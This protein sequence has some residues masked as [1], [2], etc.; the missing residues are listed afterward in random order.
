MT[1]KIGNTVEELENS[2]TTNGE[3]GYAADTGNLVIKTDT[4]CNKLSTSDYK[5]SASDCNLNYYCSDIKY[6][7]Y[8]NYLNTVNEKE[9]NEI[10][11]KEGFIITSQKTLSP[12]ETS[13][14]IG[15][16]LL[17]EKSFY[18]SYKN[19]NDRETIIQYQTP[20][21]DG[22]NIEITIIEREKT[23]QLFITP[24][25]IGTSWEL[26]EFRE[27]FIDLFNKYIE[28]VKTSGEFLEDI[29]SPRLGNLGIDGHD[30]WDGKILGPHSFPSQGD[31]TIL[32]L[33]SSSSALDEL[34]GKLTYAGQEEI[35]K[36]I[37][38][39]SIDTNN[40]ITKT[41]ASNMV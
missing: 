23:I 4:G 22:K 31:T 36:T 7:K 30:L 14:C 24:E 1:F 21:E 25:S 35:Q 11:E 38:S 29:P 34:T 37:T 18:C 27:I 32:G 13:S 5:L 2:L 16:T 19:F 9:L 12:D 39:S 26:E 3:V 41:N 15:W 10:I 28:I 33:S 6:N 40:Y 17:S 8:N 20:L